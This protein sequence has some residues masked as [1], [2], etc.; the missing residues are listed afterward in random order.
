M[1]KDYPR[2]PT[3]FH[4]E[5][6]SNCHAGTPTGR[7]HTRTGLGEDRALLFVRESQT[8]S[9]GVAMPYINLGDVTYLRHEGA[10]PMRI[11]WELVTAMPASFYQE[12]KLAAG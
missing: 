12:A 11:D 5:S 9:R 10:R 4:W 8:D 2:S 3:R 6:Q 7:R 1:Y